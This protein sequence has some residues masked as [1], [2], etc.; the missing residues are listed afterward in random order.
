LIPRNEVDSFEK[1]LCE[2][3]VEY[4][5]VDGNQFLPGPVEKIVVA[6]SEALIGVLSD[7][8]KKKKEPSEI[9][10]ETPD[11]EMQLTAENVIKLRVQFKE[12]KSK[13]KGKLKGT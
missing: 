7:Y 13:V 4:Q 6:I 8:S 12:R 9:I 5:N 3:K 10:I 2:K 1:F 11:G